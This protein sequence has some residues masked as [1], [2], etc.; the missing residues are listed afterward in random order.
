VSESDRAVDHQTHAVRPPMR[1]DIAHT[2]QDGRFQL[3]PRASR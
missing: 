2:F 1:N 3:A